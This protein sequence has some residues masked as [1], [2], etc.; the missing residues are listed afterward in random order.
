VCTFEAGLKED[1][2]GDVADDEDEDGGTL[3]EEEDAEAEM[4]CCK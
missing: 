4:A 1:R 2:V 3:E